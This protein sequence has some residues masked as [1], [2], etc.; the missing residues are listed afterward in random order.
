M[1]LPKQR[2]QNGGPKPVQLQQE[3]QRGEVQEQLQCTDSRPELQGKKAGWPLVDTA[4]F[5]IPSPVRAFLTA[6]CWT[7]KDDVSLGL[8]TEVAQ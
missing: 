5:S 4:H 3:L 8:Q 6:S 7:T 2:V 1:K